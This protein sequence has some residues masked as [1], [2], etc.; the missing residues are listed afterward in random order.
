MMKF[1][2]LASSTVKVSQIGLGAMQLGSREWGYGKEFNRDTAIKIIHRALELDINLID[3]AE[4]YAG[5]ESE[6]IIGEAIKGYDRESIIITSKFFPKAIR[7][8]SVVKALKKSL[9]RL[10]TSYVDIYLIHWPLPTPPIG[11]TLRHME[12]MV[13]EGLIR[14][15]GVSNFPKQRLEKA[16]SV[17]LKHKV[18]VNQ[19]QYSMVKNVIERELLPYARS[20]NKLI[21]AY[22]PL[23]QG[24]L[25]GKYSADKPGPK[26]IRRLNRLFTKKNLLRGE[27]L[28]NTLHEIAQEN[29][30]TMAQLALSWTIRDPTVVAIPGAKSVTQLE[31]NAN[32][33]DFQ[34]TEDV[35]QRIN[36]ALAKF[37]PKLA[38]SNR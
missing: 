12:K 34:L 13:D 21:M 2:N 8:S 9:N 24:W 27:P 4:I 1:V 20:E 25:T 29:Q 18:E 22:S 31:D 5:G 30:I 26:G 16:Q 33:A 11:R 6:R 10:Q 23:A 7:P 35:I 37:N 3:T 32:A 19:V 14:F 15:I 28:L 38:Q 17:M 36:I